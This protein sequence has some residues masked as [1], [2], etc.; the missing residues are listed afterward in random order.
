MLLNIRIEEKGRCRY[1][2]NKLDKAV[3]RGRLRGRERKEGECKGRGE[4]QT[5]NKDEGGHGG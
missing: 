3:K 2:R 5:G 1:K 4:G